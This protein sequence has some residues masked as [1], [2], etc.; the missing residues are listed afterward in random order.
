MKNNLK[1]IT[2]YI[3]V[4]ITE[5]G[6]ADPQ[7]LQGILV[8][9]AKD[10]RNIPITAFSGEVAQHIKRFIN[11]DRTSLPTIYKLVEELAEYNYMLLTKI[12]IYNK[13]NLLRANIHFKI[14]DKE[15]VLNHYRASDS[16]ALAAFYDS[17][18][19]ID[20]IMLKN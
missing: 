5:V 15:I 4:K 6:F 20:E 17:D 14:R 8:L 3:K 7:G 9:T 18:I 11:G 12:E 13:D 16:I 1:D 19:L 2:N 10:G